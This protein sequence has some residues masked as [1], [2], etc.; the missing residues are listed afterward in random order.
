MPDSTSSSTSCHRLA[1]R[2]PG[3][4][5]C[6]NSSTK[7]SGGLR[8]SASSR[9]N[10]RMEMPRCKDS[11]RGSISIPSSR[12]SV[13][14]RLCVST[15]PTN[16]STPLER[17]IRAAC[18]MAKVLPTPGDEPKNIFNLPRRS[19]AAGSSACA[20]A[21]KSSGLGRTGSMSNYAA[22]IVPR[23]SPRSRA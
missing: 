7:I 18:N 1:C 19:P 22:S 17:W 13:S 21:S 16:T 2:E 9:S 20:R 4:L 3:A 23:Y 15:K 5:V 12:A 8:F 11:W 10:S 14:C 6:A